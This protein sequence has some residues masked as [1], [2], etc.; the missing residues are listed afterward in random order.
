MSN[1]LNLSPNDF[2]AFVKDHVNF[3]WN[4]SDLTELV[5][6]DLSDDEIERYRNSYG[7]CSYDTER[8][9]K[10]N[11]ELIGELIRTRLSALTALGSYRRDR[12]RVRC[13]YTDVMK[14]S[15]QDFYDYVCGNFAS[16]FDYWYENYGFEKRWDSYASQYGV[17]TTR[18]ERRPKSSYRVVKEILVKKYDDALRRQKLEY[19]AYLALKGR[20]AALENVPDVLREYLEFKYERSSRNTPKL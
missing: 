1:I 19:H 7:I 20:G 15:D 17:E 11:K 8:V 3:E 12:S 6:E 4:W 16:Y 5:A 2:F 14:L 13:L 10:T 18:A 9:D